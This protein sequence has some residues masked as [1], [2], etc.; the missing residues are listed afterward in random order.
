[1]LAHGNCG[2]IAERCEVHVGHP[3]FVCM[4]EWNG[5]DKAARPGGGGGPPAQSERTAG[6][7]SPVRDPP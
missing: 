4:R 1:L 2:F 5:D 3:P 6:V 7:L